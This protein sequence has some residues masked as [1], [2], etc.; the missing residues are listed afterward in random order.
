[1]CGR[2]IARFVGGTCDFADVVLDLDSAYVPREDECVP[3]KVEGSTLPV[4]RGTTEHSGVTELAR[5]TLPASRVG[6][7]CGAS[8]S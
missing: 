4:E 5:E 1:M 3:G 8:L 2:G 7:G 6:V